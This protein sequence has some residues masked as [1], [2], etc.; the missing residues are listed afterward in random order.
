MSETVAPSRLSRELKDTG[1]LALAIAG[2]FAEFLSL[3][4]CLG[5]L[6]GTKAGPSM[7]IT[8]GRARTQLKGFGKVHT[9]SVYINSAVV[10]C[11]YRGGAVIH[12]G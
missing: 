11:K 12:F 7:P 5:V 10:F 6:R 1:E 3:P 9:W 4:R 2:S 8:V